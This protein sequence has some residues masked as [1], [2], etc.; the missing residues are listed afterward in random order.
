MNRRAISLRTAS[1]PSRA[2]AGRNASSTR[3]SAPGSNFAASIG[4]PDHHAYDEAAIDRLK[5]AQRARRA[6][7]HDG[8]GFRADERALRE[9][10]DVFRVRM[11]CDA[12]DGVSSL[13]LKAVSDFARPERAAHV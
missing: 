12:P 4:Y 10:I 13:A 11:T 1:S 7:H 8:E 5:K 9:G 3:F 2:S 6:P